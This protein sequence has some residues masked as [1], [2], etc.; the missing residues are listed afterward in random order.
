MSVNAVS[1]DRGQ[2]CDKDTKL[3][4][5]CHDSTFKAVT[6]LDS[7]GNILYTV[8]S[9]GY[10]SMSWRRIVTDASGNTVFE[11]RHLGNSLRNEWALQS[12][13]DGKKLA[14]FRRPSKSARMRLGLDGVVH[15][16]ASGNG[17]DEVVI[18]A[19]PEHG[20]EH[21]A[22][23]DV[24]GHR[25]ARIENVENNDVLDREGKGLDRSVWGVQ[26]MKGQDMSLVGWL[27]VQNVN[28]Y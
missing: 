13:K 15:C 12:A 7:V 10:A 17:K 26:V 14:S 16:N 5:K 21:V 11:L 19:S 8:K 27:D 1:I 22:V 3:V 9:S 2:V 23:V 24:E 28:G 20:H 18:E 6:V 4:V 25:A